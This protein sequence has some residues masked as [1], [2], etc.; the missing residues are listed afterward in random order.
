LATAAK[1]GNGLPLLETVRAVAGRV[2]HSPKMNAG[3]RRDLED[4]ITHYF[5]VRA[6]DV[7]ED[8][9]AH[10]QKLGYTP[11]LREP[12]IAGVF[13]GLQSRYP[14]TRIEEKLEAAGVSL[15]R[16]EKI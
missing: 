11:K 10:L 7:L 5:Y 3:E 12:F 2:E 15:G 1:N 9:P 13:F 4:L 8:L 14:K 16:K 6:E